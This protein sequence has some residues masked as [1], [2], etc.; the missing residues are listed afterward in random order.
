MIRFTIFVL[1]AAIA[2]LAALAGCATPEIVQATDC[3]G[4]VQPCGIVYAP[5]AAHAMT[6]IPLTLPVSAIP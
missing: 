1:G 4:A 2:V 6:S 3:R 5:A